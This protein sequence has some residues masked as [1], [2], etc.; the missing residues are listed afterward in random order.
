MAKNREF[1]DDM[2]EIGKKWLTLRGKSVIYMTWKI[3]NR[4]YRDAGKIKCIWIRTLGTGASV[5][6]DA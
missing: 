6:R 3:F 4:R 2:E 5:C 1:D